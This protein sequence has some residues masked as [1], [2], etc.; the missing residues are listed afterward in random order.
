MYTATLPSRGL[1]LDPVERFLVPELKAPP[2]DEA[3]NGH[4]Y[5][6]W[7]DAAEALP[8]RPFYGESSSILARASTVGSA[9]AESGTAAATAVLGEARG[10]AAAAAAVVRPDDAQPQLRPP[11]A[12]REEMYSGALANL[13]AMG[14][15]ERVSVSFLLTTE[16]YQLGCVC[17]CGS[18]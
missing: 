14:F 6:S 4:T 2:T 12:S 8:L 13:L 16:H 18:V 3:E 1:K 7:G 15:D 5:E 10:E 11:D 9:M 17:E